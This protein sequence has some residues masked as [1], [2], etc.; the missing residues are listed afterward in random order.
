MFA[1]KQKVTGH[2][3]RDDRIYEGILGFNIML[4]AGFYP[5]H[6]E[7]TLGARTNA[8]FEI[9]FGDVVIAVVLKENL[10]GGRGPALCFRVI[11]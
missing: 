4:A 8:R 6:P 9:P 2:F 5:S 1:I 11:V 3:T 10:H 7:R